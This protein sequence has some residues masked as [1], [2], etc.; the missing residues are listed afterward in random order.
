[1]TFKF[2]AKNLQTGKT[3]AVTVKADRETV[4]RQK[5]QLSG[6]E[7]VRLMRITHG[8]ENSPKM[9]IL[10]ATPSTCVPRAFQN[11]SPRLV[12][13]IK[14]SALVRDLFAPFALFA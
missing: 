8:Q 4:A 9:V 12:M 6:Y 14:L 3:G 13:K 10:S 5:L 7:V 2:V 11:P 1:M